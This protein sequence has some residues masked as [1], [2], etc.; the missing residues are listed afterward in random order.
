MTTDYIYIYIFRGRKT[1]ECAKLRKITMQRSSLKK[2]QECVKRRHDMQSFWEGIMVSEGPEK[3]EKEIKE[4][5]VP[6][7]ICIIIWS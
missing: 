1:S 5:K 3:W 4:I 2:I 6:V 7:I